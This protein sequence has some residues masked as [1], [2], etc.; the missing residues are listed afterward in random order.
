MDRDETVRI[1][2]LVAFGGLTA[3][4]ISK[5]LIEYCTI[6]HDKSIEDTNKFISTLLQYQVFLHSYVQEALEYYERKF[7]IH[8]LWSAPSPLN[9]MGQ[10]RKL[11]Q[12]F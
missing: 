8:K 7:A 9:N 5:L 4:D 10:K 12:I 3:D 1:S 2:R 6:D 11:L